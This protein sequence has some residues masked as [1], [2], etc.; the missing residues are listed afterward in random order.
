MGPVV[1]S[2]SRCLKENDEGFG[3]GLNFE[4]RGIK[5][6]RWY[7][8]LIN[9]II[10]CLDG[11][12]FDST[13]HL[14]I[15]NIVDKSMLT[16]CFKHYIELYP[17]ILGSEMINNV[18]S[19]FTQDVYSENFHYYIEG[20][21]AT[22]K[23][24][25]SQ[26]NTVRALCYVRYACFKA[27][28][29]E[30]IDYFVE[31]CGDDTIIFMEKD[32]INKFEETTFQ[33]VYTKNNYDVPTVH[34]LGQIARFIEKHDEISGVEYISCHLISDDNNNIVLVRKP[35]RFFQ[36]TPF[37]INNKHKS[38]KKRDKLNMGLSRGDA[39]CIKAWCHDIKL[40]NEYANTLLRICDVKH[41]VIDYGF[42]SYSEKKDSR[43]LKIWKHYKTFLYKKYGVTNDDLKEY[44]DVIKNIKTMYETV[45]C[46]LIDKI[47][48]VDQV[49]KSH[50]VSDCFLTCQ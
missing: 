38:V 15:L 30:G 46:S 26:G 48:R 20:T 41:H 21:Q 36:M 42:H 2:I 9:P 28:L 43:H 37:T 11:S 4:D 25:T 50:L 6:S 45:R 19:D 14:D 8:K 27:G 32:L 22:G 18:L 7:S 35:D 33:Y 3:S 24:N 44:F 47:M 29:I 16:Y 23:M 13:Q 39:F 31:A 40:F 5:F 1:E 10:L 34:G 12:A 49:D 17:D